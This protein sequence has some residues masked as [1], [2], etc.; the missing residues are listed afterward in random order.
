MQPT[1]HNL[2][3]LVARKDGEKEGSRPGGPDDQMLPEFLI[4][5]SD[6]THMFQALSPEETT[7][8]FILVPLWSLLTTRDR[9]C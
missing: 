1:A 4:P 6:I 9:E 2:A 8:F 5:H 3:M 7:G